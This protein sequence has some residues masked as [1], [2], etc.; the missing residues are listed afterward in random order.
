MKSILYKAVVTEKEN[1]MTQV[2]ILRPDLSLKVIEV[3]YY[4]WKYPDSYEQE[5]IKQKLYKSLPVITVS[6]SN[7]T[8]MEL[9]ENIKID[10][11]TKK[12][13]STELSS[14]IVSGPVK[15]IIELNEVK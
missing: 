7:I 1:F 2:R 14:K 15:I 8:D 11:R 3:L 4:I 12:I 6:L 10:K 5:L 9:L 13:L